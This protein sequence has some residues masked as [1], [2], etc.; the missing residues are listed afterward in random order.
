MILRRRDLAREA[1]SR[2]LETRKRAGFDFESPLCVYDLAARLGLRVR[3]D[4]INMEGVYRAEGRLI[5]L[6]S[7]RPLSRRAFS[8]AH[9]IGHDAYGHA[10]AIDELIEATGAQ[11]YDEEEFLVQT[12]A[13]ILLMPPVGVAFEFARR[14]WTIAN[15]TPEQVFTVACAFGVGY[16]TLADHLAYGLR[17]ISSS[18]ALAL[19]R[20]PVREIRRRLVGARFQIRERMFVADSEYCRPTLDVEVGAYL[21]LPEQAVLDSACEGARPRLVAEGT[22]GMW[23]VL[24]AVRPGMVRAHVPGTAWATFV[25]ISRY[26]YTGWDKYRHL[27]LADDDD[28]EAD[29]ESQ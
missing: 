8:C 1:N 7:L 13:G 26:Q 21:V 28:D 15:A 27:E 10:Q 12:F 6:P 11:E 19:K 4:P 22:H 2:A 9:E 16:E 23:R 14:R 3:F 25:R 24:S 29:D 20:V 5:V 18:Q 17:M